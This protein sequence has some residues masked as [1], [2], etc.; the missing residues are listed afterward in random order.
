MLVSLQTPLQKCYEDAQPKALNGCFVTYAYLSGS[1]AYGTHDEDS[2]YDVVCVLVAPWRYY[3]GLNLDKMPEAVEL[4]DVKFNQDGKEC[5]AG[6]RYYELRH[7]IKLAFKNNPSILE[8]IWTDENSVIYHGSIFPEFRKVRQLFLS[9][10]KS[11]KAFTGYAM[12][13]M[14][15]MNA[16]TVSTGRM[17]AKRKELLDK[18]GYDTKNACHLMR[19]LYCALSIVEKDELRVHMGDLCD[20]LKAIRDGVFTLH[21]V[22]LTAGELS[23]KAALLMEERE[24]AGN[25]IKSEPEVIEQILIRKL[26]DAKM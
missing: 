2:D 14:R 25:L 6:I 11:Y 10:E 12:D 15:K 20:E 5:L 22:M 16:T 13:Q 1:R 23:E 26:L 18:F 3:L 19:M 21:E 17:G 8:G 24:V 4:K 7:F 9:T